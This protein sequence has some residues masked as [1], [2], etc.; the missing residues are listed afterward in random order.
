MAQGLWL[1]GRGA[2]AHPV[3]ASVGHAE[4][5]E[6]A[7]HF[8]SVRPRPTSSRIP[9]GSVVATTTANPTNLGRTGAERS[10]AFS[11]LGHWTTPARL[12]SRRR[13]SRGRLPIASLRPRIELFR[14]RKGQ[15]VL[16]RAAVLR[17]WLCLVP[18]GRRRLAADPPGGAGADDVGRPAVDG[19]PI[20]KPGSARAPCLRSGQRHR[21][22]AAVG[23]IALRQCDRRAGGAVRGRRTTEF[24][25]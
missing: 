14:S 7:T 13:A 1:Q 18:T 22:L 10:P 16:V 12:L 2:V 25:R 8:A 20:R 19:R 21:R 11:L 5:R 17:G 15:E 9:F 23:T 6:L 3:R 4:L 24:G